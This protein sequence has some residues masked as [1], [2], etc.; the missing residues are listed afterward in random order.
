MVAFSVSSMCVLALSL[1][2]SPHTPSQSLTVALAGFQLRDLSCLPFCV[3][4]CL[5]SSQAALGCVTT[6]MKQDQA[7]TFVRVSRAGCIIKETLLHSARG[8]QDDS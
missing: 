4:E 8:E 7:H 2:L 6:R 5:D 3:D 1:F